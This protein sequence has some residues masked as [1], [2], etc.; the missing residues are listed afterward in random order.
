MITD[1]ITETEYM[2]FVASAFI[3]SPETGLG[4]AQQ[5][6]FPGATAGDLV[7]IS[8]MS[9]FPSSPS[10][11]VNT[12]IHNPSQLATATDACLRQIQN[13]IH[14]YSLSNYTPDSK[15]GLPSIAA[16]TTSSQ[17]PKP[18]LISGRTRKLVSI[19]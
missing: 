1:A 16:A 3:D 10:S 7:S 4:N 2:T 6:F 17:S 11:F 12:D 5:I 14:Q 13:S 8:S 19:L 18:V 9:T 15:T